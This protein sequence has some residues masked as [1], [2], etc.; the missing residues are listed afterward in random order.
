MRLYIP[1]HV[2]SDA[3]VCGNDKDGAA[4]AAAGRPGDIMVG[5]DIDRDVLL[6]V[7]S[8]YADGA[9]SRTP[10]AAAAAAAAATALSS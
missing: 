10:T 4:A 1:G 8:A 6:P 9:K 3:G 7:L 5:G 2:P